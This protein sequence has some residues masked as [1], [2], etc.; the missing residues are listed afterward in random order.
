[1][2]ASV[3]CTDFHHAVPPSRSI[4][5]NHNDWRNTTMQAILMIRMI[6][7]RCALFAVLAAGTVLPSAQAQ[8][9][10]QN[11]KLGNKASGSTQAQ[12]PVESSKAAETES[13]PANKEHA[14]GPR[15]RL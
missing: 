7:V 3:Q 6:G 11:Q 2:T 15:S 14:G 4:Q 8:S 13:A 9:S 5:Y 1:M 12:P 10:N